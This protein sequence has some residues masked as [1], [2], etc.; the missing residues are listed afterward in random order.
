MNK[1]QIYLDGQFFTYC[2]A[3]SEAKAIEQTAE[4][5]KNLAPINMSP[6]G[7]IKYR[8]RFENCVIT[9]KMLYPVNKFGRFKK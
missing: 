6:E 5:L 4:Q 7:I 8:K 3:T 2:E 9:T 1:Y